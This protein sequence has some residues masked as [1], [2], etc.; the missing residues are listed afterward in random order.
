MTAR[1]IEPILYLGNPEW[2]SMSC[3]AGRIER[4]SLAVGPNAKLIV[5]VLRYLM[6]IVLSP[7][8]TK[9]KAER[10][11]STTKQGDT[12]HALP[13]TPTFSRSL[14]T[15][16]ENTRPRFAFCFAISLSG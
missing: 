3:V 6:L 5:S 11:G 1:C 10:A 12:I 14:L 9:A 4:R 16:D 15:A 8:S 2:V 13:S 7:T